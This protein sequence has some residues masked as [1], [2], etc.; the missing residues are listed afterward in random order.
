MWPWEHLAFGY[1]LFSLWIHVR[2]RSF[3]RS[4]ASMPPG[5]YAVWALALGTQ[6]PDLID[7]PGAW[8]F[9]VLP[10]GISLAHS[11]LISVP[12]A[13]LAVL[14]GRRLGHAQT[15]EGFAIGYL[16]HL[17]GDVISPLVLQRPIPTLLWPLVSGNVDNGPFIGR[18]L[19]E[20]GDFLLFLTTPTGTVYLLAEG[21]FL[22][23]A[24]A[25]WRRHGYPGIG[26]FRRLLQP[27][28]A[29]Q[30]GE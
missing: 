19:E 11:M 17:A 28:E 21:A 9:G 2:S 1:I 27:S 7:K 15:G 18:V 5:E 23:L 8:V 10:S 26:V 29:N 16:S 30:A 3:S 24:V 25:L 22:A 12:V 20:F 14:I 6:L 13:L 4:V